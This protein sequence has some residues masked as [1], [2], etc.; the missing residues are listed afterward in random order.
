MILVLKDSVKLYLIVAS[1]PTSSKKSTP[2][3]A[4]RSIPCFAIPGVL[5]WSKP[6]HADGVMKTT[7]LNVKVLI[8]SCYVRDIPDSDLVRNS[9]FLN[10]AA[11]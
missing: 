2:A 9:I 3:A 4:V 11:L 6:K 7:R 10:D 5:I 1:T 8:G